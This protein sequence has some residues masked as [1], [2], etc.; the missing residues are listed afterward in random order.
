MSKTEMTK[1]KI[2]RS[3]VN[4]LCQQNTYTKDSELAHKVQAGLRRATVET[5]E[6]LLV[7]VKEQ[8]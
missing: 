2:V 5:L 1:K 4:R 3:I 8:R 7:L 6:Q